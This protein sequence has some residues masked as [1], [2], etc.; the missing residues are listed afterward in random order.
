MQNFQGL[1]KLRLI[2]TTPALRPVPFMTWRE[3]I[4]RVWEVDPLLCP[5]CGTEMVKLA[6]IKIPKPA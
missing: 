4:K 6:T 1:E 2:L 5:R 3:L